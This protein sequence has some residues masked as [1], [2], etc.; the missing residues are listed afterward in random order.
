MRRLKSTTCR[1]LSHSPAQV[2]WR[3]R[4]FSVIFRFLERF[5]IEHIE[6]KDSLN[7]FLQNDSIRSIRIPSRIRDIFKKPQDHVFNS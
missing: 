3:C 6:T 2:G 4:G 5:R 1:K 7:S